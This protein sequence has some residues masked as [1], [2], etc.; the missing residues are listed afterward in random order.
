[1][2]REQTTE[3]MCQDQFNQLKALAPKLIHFLDNLTQNQDYPA[4]AHRDFKKLV[5]I[6]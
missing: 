2:R 1:M 6:S 4:A 3:E 5:S